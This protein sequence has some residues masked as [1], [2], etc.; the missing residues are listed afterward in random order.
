[1]G[2]DDR[3]LFADSTDHWVPYT[4][5][6]GARSIPIVDTVWAPLC[7]AQRVARGTVA[8]VSPRTHFAKWYANAAIYR[9][10]RD[11]VK[12]ALQ[13]SGRG[14]EDWRC[15][16]Y[17]WA[18]ETLWGTEIVNGNLGNIHGRPYATRESILAG[19]VWTSLTPGPTG[20]SIVHDDS[21]VVVEYAFDSLAAWCAYEKAW[22]E[23]CGYQGVLDGY[24]A[25]ELVGLLQASEAA[26]RRGYAAGGTVAGDAANCRG[27]WGDPPHVY[28]WSGRV[29][30]GDLRAPG[31]APHDGPSE[32]TR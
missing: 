12:A 9:A 19:N 4:G 32:W 29:V 7:E 13:A 26:M 31:V 10:T 25:G 11:A 24:R 20:A 27:Y 28:R 16:L 6:A 5:Q 2:Q 1:M 17:R 14:D 21:Q 18:N 15:V 30:L 23:R 8:D 3:Q 22:Y